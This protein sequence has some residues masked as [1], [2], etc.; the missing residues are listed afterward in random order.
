VGSTRTALKHL[1]IDK[2]L[3]AMVEP[4]EHATLRSVYFSKFSKWVGEHRS[5]PFNDF[6]EQ[7]YHY[8]K[9]YRLYEHLLKAERLDTEAIDYLEFGVHQGKSITWWASQN[10]NPTSSYVGFDTFT[11][12][13]EEWNADRPRGFFST[14]GQTPVV[15]D[16]R[17]G[18]RAGLFQHTLHEFLEGRRFDRK[19]MVHLDADLYSSTL[20]VLFELAR[21]L[22]TGDVLLFDEFSDPL[23][24]FRA[25]LDF[26]SSYP[27]RYELIGA[28]NGYHQVAFRIL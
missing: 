7:D 24:E 13:P 18:F 6:G 1:F 23:H 12:L 16:P 3:H 22:K 11:G 21:H 2:G 28:V 26:L 5:A 27:I 14:G 25:W 8:D 19:L 17:V 15:D 9:R 10:S 4:V 20:F